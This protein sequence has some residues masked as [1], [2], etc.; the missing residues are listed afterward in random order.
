[1]PTAAAA[2]AAAGAV[3][4]TTDECATC[5]SSD[6]ETSTCVSSAAAAD[7]RP[8]E[9]PSVW[10]LQRHREPHC[11]RAVGASQDGSHLESCSQQQLARRAPC[12]L[13]EWRCAHASTHASA[14]SPTILCRGR[15]PRWLPMPCLRCNTPSRTRGPAVSRQPCHTPCRVMGVLER[16]CV[17]RSSHGA[18]QGRQLLHL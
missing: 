13:A 9:A 3:C 2:A 17:E 6:S 15:S 18:I 1:M 8:R 12:H 5:T 14:L 4:V 7:Q 16:Q 11:C 10:R